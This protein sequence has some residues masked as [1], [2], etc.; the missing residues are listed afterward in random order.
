VIGGLEEECGQVTGRSVLH[1][2]LARP[3]IVPQ[4]LIHAIPPWSLYDGIL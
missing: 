4:L 1:S 3:A 2:Q